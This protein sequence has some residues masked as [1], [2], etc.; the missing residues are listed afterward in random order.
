MS[1]DTSKK[2]MSI[3]YSKLSRIT[4][5]ILR[6]GKDGTN[7]FY[8]YKYVSADNVAAIIAPMLARE[9]IALLSETANVT[10]TANSYL[11]EYR[12]TFVCGDTGYR[13]PCTWFGEIAHT[14]KNG[15]YDDKALNKAATISQKYFILKTFMV[16]TGDDPD[17]DSPDKLDKSGKHSH[18]PQKPVNKPIADDS[19]KHD[20]STDDEWSTWTPAI[21]QKLVLGIS[22]V[23]PGSHHM[24][25]SGY[26]ALDNKE[27][28]QIGTPRQV[29][30]HLIDWNY[31]DKHPVVVR[32]MRYV[33]N[34]KSGKKY[35]Q[36]AAKLD[37]ENTGHRIINAFGRTTG[38]KRLLD[39]VDENLYNDNC[40]S[41]YDDADETTEWSELVVPMTIIY[42]GD[43]HLKLAGIVYN[44]EPHFIADKAVVF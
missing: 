37:T 39:S 18:Q 44:G 4:G 43:E 21:K 35:L 31:E 24:R 41:S 10:A 1:E 8:N 23:F 19:Q 30:R 2:D 13:E 28:E 38:V 6:I 12:F 11:C 17:G 29:A 40:F 5:E 15:T 9:N 32:Y 22:E 7:K 42:D 36:F 20:K 16:A 14:S 3:F 26:N 34:N 25:L 27:F 33:I